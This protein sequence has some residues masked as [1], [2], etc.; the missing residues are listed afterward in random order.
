MCLRAKVVF[1]VLAMALCVKSTAFAGPIIVAGDSVK[2]SDGPGTTNGGEFIVLVNNSW[3]FITFCLQRTQFINFTNVYHVDAVSTYAST[4][5]A[6]NGGDAFGRD[7]LSQQ[8]AFLYTMFR[9]GNLAGYNYSGS[10]RPMSANHLQSAIGMFEHELPMDASNPFVILA[11]N[12]VTS[13]AWSG[14]GS[15]RALNLS[16]NGAEAQDQLAL[17]PEPASL[18]LL[19]MGLL[20]LVRSVRRRRNSSHLVARPH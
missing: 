5:P 9:N 10:G 3:S 11:N 2:L 20:G 13:G 18:T 14:L 7:Y 4:D 19:G 17:V 6:A 12:A 8:T 1:L 15:V 16:L